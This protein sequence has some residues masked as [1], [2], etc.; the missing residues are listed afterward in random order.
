MTQTGSTA[1]WKAREA[2]GRGST[3]ALPARTGLSWTGCEFFLT[4]SDNSSGII[5]LTSVSPPPL[6]QKMELATL[7]SQPVRSHEHVRRGA[8]AEAHVRSLPKQ[9][10]DCAPQPPKCGR[11]QN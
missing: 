7:A 5:L 1:T 6:I 11:S 2:Q 9:A 8:Q 10:H 4:S 3:C